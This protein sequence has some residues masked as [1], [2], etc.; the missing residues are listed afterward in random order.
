MKSEMNFINKT[1]LLAKKEKNNEKKKLREENE[2][3]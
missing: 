3:S 1:H 2:N